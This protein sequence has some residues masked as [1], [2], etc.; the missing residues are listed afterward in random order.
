M[1]VW[2]RFSPSRYLNEQGDNDETYDYDDV[3]WKG[4]RN[5]RLIKNHLSTLFIVCG[6]LS[7]IIGCSG[8]PKAINRQPSSAY[9]SRRFISKCLA[10]IATIQGFAVVSV[11]ISTLKSAAAA[12]NRAEAIAKLLQFH[13]YMH[14]RLL[15]TV[16]I[17]AANRSI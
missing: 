8:L 3:G 7:L 1:D 11:S 14:Q 2:K 9:S 12:N 10:W 4:R 15:N 16:S 5:V 17:P 13:L 6:G